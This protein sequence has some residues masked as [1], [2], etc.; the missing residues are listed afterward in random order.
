M[1][2]SSSS[3]VSK[4]DKD[5]KSRIKKFCDD[6]GM[7]SSSTF[8][9]FPFSNEHKFDE[10]IKKLEKYDPC[11]TDKLRIAVL[12]GESNFLSFLP[13][14]KKHADIVILDDINEKIHKHTEHLL[15]CLIKSDSIKE[16]LKNYEENHPLKSETWK[17]KVIPKNRTLMKMYE[18]KEITVDELLEDLKNQKEVSCKDKH[19]LSSE[20]I[21]M[22]CKKA[23][24]ELTFTHANI[25][26]LNQSECQSLAKT[27]AKHDAIV[28]V[29]NMTNLHD[30]DSRRQIPKTVTNLL[31]PAEVKSTN[32]NKDSVILYSTGGVGIG[33]A[34]TSQV[35][36]G[37]QAYL[38]F[39]DSLH[40]DEDQK[41]RKKQKSQ[42]A[43]ISIDWLSNF[44]LKNKSNLMLDFCAGSYAQSVLRN[45]ANKEKFCEMVQSIQ[46]GLK[47]NSDS[48]EYKKVK[49]ALSMLIAIV[50]HNGWKSYVKNDEEIR[51]LAEDLSSSSQGFLKA[52]ISS[53]S[54]VKPK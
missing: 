40:K 10:T 14:L 42:D 30:Y 51:K 26:L 32:E 16:F 11:K 53:S 29:L 52:D 31:H 36:Q 25:N 17:R 19:F 33:S 3:L 2:S 39:I 12:V 37:E 50:N 7:S 5:D 47:T 38:K 46:D 1:S 44:I 8:E 13:A 15:S 48:D 9:F 34:L 35:T 22:Q 23:A 41:E 6:I 28:T 43:C 54:S 27:L 45:K 20:E 24:S 21:F 4:T 18:W 49:N